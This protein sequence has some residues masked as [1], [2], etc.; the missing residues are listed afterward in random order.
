MVGRCTCNKP[1]SAKSFG[2]GKLILLIKAKLM[3]GG[4]G[5]FY[6]GTGVQGCRKIQHT[7]EG[8]EK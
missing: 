4:N 7:F 8:K 5:L 2:Q 3:A 1:S 6:L